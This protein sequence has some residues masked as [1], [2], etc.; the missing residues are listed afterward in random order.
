MKVKIRFSQRETMT[1]SEGVLSKDVKIIPTLT[2]IEITNKDGELIKDTVV[3]ALGSRL[4]QKRF[5]ASKGW[6]K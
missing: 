6:A 3:T 4:A 2:G 1:V 5:T